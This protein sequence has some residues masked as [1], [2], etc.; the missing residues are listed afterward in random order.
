MR[1][2][3]TKRSAMSLE[4]HGHVHVASLGSMVVT[5][6]KKQHLHKTGS[7]QTCEDSY[8]VHRAL[9]QEPW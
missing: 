2:N 6:A 5:L 8:H 7:Y 4:Q 9:P 3:A 1:R